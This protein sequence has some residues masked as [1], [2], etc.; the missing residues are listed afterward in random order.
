[1]GSYTPDLSKAELGT[2][3]V[4]APPIAYASAPTITYPSL[5]MATSIPS[6]AYASPPMTASIS[7]A[8]YPSL[9]MATSI[10]A[11]G[12]ASPP[13]I[14]LTPAAAYAS[15]SST[16]S[17]PGT[18]PATAT[19]PVPVTTPESVPMPSTYQYYPYQRLQTLH[20][21]TDINKIN[22]WLP[23]SIGNLFIGGIILGLFPMAFSLI[24]RSKKRKN[25]IKGA[26]TMSSLAVLSNII[27]TA[28]GVVALSVLI[29][30]L[31]YR[32]KP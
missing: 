3:H 28:I 14:A 16:V 12:Y 4:S 26:R 7:A 1:M 9:P 10:P 22:D 5:P 23:W 2:A 25:D 20:V 17:V 13:M 30:Y 29:F 32:Q 8:A 15:S 21:Q 27:I 6:V 18:L 11:A 24:C 31:I 19:A